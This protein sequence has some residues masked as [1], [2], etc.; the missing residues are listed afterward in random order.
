MPNPV[1]TCDRLCW[2]SIILLVPTIPARIR[3][4][5]NHQMGLNAKISAKAN[6]APVTPPI[7][8]VCVETFHHT[9]IRAQSIW[10]T[11]AAM[12]IMVM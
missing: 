1:S 3:T 9:L 8:A 7:A 4:I 11:R 5:H 12:R 6:N 10:M 2:R